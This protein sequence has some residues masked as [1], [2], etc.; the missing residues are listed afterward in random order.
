MRSGSMDSM[1]EAAGD[2]TDSPTRSTGSIGYGTGSD[3]GGASLD[4][5]TR[6]WLSF[7]NGNGLPA[8]PVFADEF[9]VEARGRGLDWRV[10]P[11][12]VLTCE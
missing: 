12:D 11:Q 2:V 9:D 6:D 5:Y 3:A 8:L 10:F 7:E 1:D 4:P